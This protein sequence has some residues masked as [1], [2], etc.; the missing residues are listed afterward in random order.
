MSCFKKEMIFFRSAGSATPPNMA[1]MLFPGMRVF[2]LVIHLSSVG[3]SQVIP[4]PLTDSEYAK[5]VTVPALRPTTP[6]R[7]G[8]SLLSSF[9]NEWHSRQWP[10]N[11]SSRSSLL[12]AVWAAVAGCKPWL[13]AGAFGAGAGA[14]GARAA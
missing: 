1:P 7:F 10:L 3:S 9:T 8:P 13:D 14:A 11:A 2:G 5:L 12:G 6:Y 4:D